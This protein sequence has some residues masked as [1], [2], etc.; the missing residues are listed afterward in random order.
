MQT[1]HVLQVDGIL[2]QPHQ[3]SSKHSVHLFG[4]MYSRLLPL[5]RGAYN[6]A[7]LMKA[8]I[9]PVFA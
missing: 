3:Y 7:K 1:L 4:A 2:I 9:S 6:E 5:S 8:Q